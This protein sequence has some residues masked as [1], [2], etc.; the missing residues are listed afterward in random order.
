LKRPVDIILAA[1]GVVVLS[2]VWLS[3]AAPILVEAGCAIL[4]RQRRWG[5][6]QRTFVAFKFR[7]MVKNAES[8]YGSV[9]AGEGDL[10]IAR[11]GRWLRATAMDEL[12]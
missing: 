10:R 4:F 11:V 8:L 7:S 6:H 2:P 1:L 9:Q 5:R 12:P 3:I